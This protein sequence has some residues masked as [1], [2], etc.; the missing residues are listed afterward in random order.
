[1]LNLKTQEFPY[2]KQFLSINFV[3]LLKVIIRFPIIITLLEETIKVANIRMHM[4][5]RCCTCVSQCMSV[6]MQVC[7]YV[8]IYYMNAYVVYKVYLHTF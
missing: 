8:Y 7:V 3:M 1:M 4:C 6:C 2:K 5:V